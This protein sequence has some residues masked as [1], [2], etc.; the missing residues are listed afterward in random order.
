MLAFPGSTS[1]STA[2]FSKLAGALLGKANDGV[3][4]DT[5]QSSDRGMRH[6]YLVPANRKSG[7]SFFFVIDQLV[8]EIHRT[9]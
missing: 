8:K 6:K 7:S 5:R 4:D 1:S 2:K 3:R 9:L